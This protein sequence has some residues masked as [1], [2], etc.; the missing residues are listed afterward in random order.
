MIS[1][2]TVDARARGK[3]KIMRTWRL[4][5]GQDGEE[6]EG[7]DDTGKLKMGWGTGFSEG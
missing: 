7:K 4:S 5:A 1:S 6:G 3:G 2:R